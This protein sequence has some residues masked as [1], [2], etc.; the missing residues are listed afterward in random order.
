MSEATFSP[1][2]YAKVYDTELNKFISLKATPDREVL[3]YMYGGSFEEFIN[4]IEEYEIIPDDELIKMYNNITDPNDPSF[5]EAITYLKN[6]ITSL[7]RTDKLDDLG[8]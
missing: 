2:V 5:S 1:R 7:R 3:R 8:I 4:D 6:Y